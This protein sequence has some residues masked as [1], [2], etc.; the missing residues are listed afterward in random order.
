[1]T[2][3]TQDEPNLETALR[4]DLGLLEWQIRDILPLI[5]ARYVPRSEAPLPSI[6][7]NDINGIDCPA[8]GHPTLML[9]SG[10]YIT[11]CM[12]DCPNPDYAE[13]LEAAREQAVAEARKDAFMNKRIVCDVCHQV[14]TFASY[15]YNST[16]ARTGFIGKL[17]FAEETSAP[18]NRGK[19]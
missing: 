16:G 7:M 18:Q 4:K 8:C 9:M 2:N 11:C 13:A 10:N 19:G 1:M 15:I 3:P 14:E 5:E 6:H 12:A 17:C